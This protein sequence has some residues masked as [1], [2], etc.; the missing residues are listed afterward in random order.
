[1]FSK[2]LLQPF[3]IV[4]NGRC[5]VSRTGPMQPKTNE[6]LHPAL[7]TYFASRS[8]LFKVRVIKDSELAGH[9]CVCVC[10]G[11]LQLSAKGL[12]RGP[13]CCRMPSAPTIVGF[14]GIAQPAVEQPVAVPGEEIKQRGPVAIYA[15][16]CR[17]SSIENLDINFRHCLKFHNKTK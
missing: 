6:T 2:K 3:C 4:S 1:M 15:N 11:D 9:Q 14:V 8:H 12:Q 7:K 13:P 17:L 10:G 16:R 5:I